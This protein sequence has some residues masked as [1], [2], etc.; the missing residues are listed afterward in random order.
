MEF[1]AVSQF[2]S[3]SDRVKSVDIHSEKPLLLT[4]LHTGTI[5]IWNYE[6]KTLIKAL[7]ICEKS[8]RCAKFIPRKNWIV[9]GS[10]DKQI[11]VFDSESFELIHSFE[12]HSDFI[13]S[14]AV[15]PTLPYLIS[16]SDDK[17][18]KIWDWENEWRLEQTMIGHDH[19]VMQIA[20]NPYDP[21]VIISAS[22]DKT[23]KI[24]KLGEEKEIASLEGHLKA[25]N[26]VA[27][28]DKKRIITGSDDQ[29]IRIWNYETRECIETLQGAHQNNVTFMA[30][31]NDC[32]IS[33]SED[34][35]IKIWN[36]KSYRLGKEL[37]YSM[38]R[39]WC[40]CVMEPDLVSVGFDNG[41]MTFKI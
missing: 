20:I 30:T 2:V 29:S 19:Y 40:V 28:L 17:T 33:G 36:S 3:H 11:R 23:L 13:R 37:N 16:A 21:N 35:F 27:F 24:W 1:D 12:S 6:T 25:V 18:I 4:A 14:F 9:T 5:Q 34:G 32:F 41:S 22:L 10:D 39:V 26:C 38:G 15:H 7:E 31:F 8:V